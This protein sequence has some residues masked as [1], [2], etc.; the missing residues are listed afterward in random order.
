MCAGDVK[1]VCVC[2]CV[3]HLSCSCCT[4]VKSS[5]IVKILW[6]VRSIQGFQFTLLCK[7]K[8]RSK[9]IK[10]VFRS[11]EPF[12][13][14]SC[15]RTLAFILVSDFF[16]FLRLKQLPIV[17]GQALLKH[18]VIYFLHLMCFSPAPESLLIEVGSSFSSA[19]SGQNKKAATEAVSKEPEACSCWTF[20]ASPPDWASEYKHPPALVNINI[21]VNINSHQP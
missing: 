6:L 11:F 16:F 1:L 20:S 4:V 8:E 13:F 9:H 7:A 2:V 21:Q 17:R 18:M 10:R 12:M 3:Q 15:F 14:G 19:V 5:V